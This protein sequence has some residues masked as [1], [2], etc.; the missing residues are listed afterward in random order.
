MCK[1]VGPQNLAPKTALGTLREV[2]MNCAETALKV[3]NGGATKPCPDHGGNQKETEKDGSS[4]VEPADGWT[5]VDRCR[6][7]QMSATQA[8]VVQTDRGPTA[9][10][11]C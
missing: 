5:A 4:A 9:L 6:A 1:T 10:C 7:V 3:Q 11:A 8:S 2:G